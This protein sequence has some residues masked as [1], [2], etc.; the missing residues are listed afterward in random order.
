MSGEFEAVNILI[1]GAVQ[2][3]ILATGKIELSA[4]ARVTADI[5]TKLISVQSGAILNDHCQTNIT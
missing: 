4:T 5:E 1:Q 2:G 3:K